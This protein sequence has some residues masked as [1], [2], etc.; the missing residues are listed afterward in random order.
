VVQEVL[1][2]GRWPGQ[3]CF[4]GRRQNAEALDVHGD[5]S[6]HVLQVR[7]RLAFE[8]APCMPTDH[9]AA[10]GNSKIPGRG[11]LRG[12]AL[13]QGDMDLGAGAP[14]RPRLLAVGVECVVCPHNAPVEHAIPR[15]SFGYVLVPDEG[16]GSL[17]AICAA[18]RLRVLLVTPALSKGCLAGNMS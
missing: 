9:A 13:P 7:F 3:G 8:T 2:G 11:K 16:M 15:G 1:E 5:G 10:L 17:I 12:S 18:L 4:A 14:T 6:E